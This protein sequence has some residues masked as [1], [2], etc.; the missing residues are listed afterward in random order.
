MTIQNYI[1]LFLS[2]QKLPEKKLLKMFR[3][4][5]PTLNRILAKIICL[6]SKYVAVTLQM[7]I[8]LTL[9]FDSDICN[10]KCNL[11]AKWLFRF[12]KK[13]NYMT[14]Q[15]QVILEDIMQQCCNFVDQVWFTIDA[16]EIRREYIIYMDKTQLPFKI[17]VKQT[18]ACSREDKECKNVLHL[19]LVCEFKW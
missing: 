9:R 1:H 17:E 5:C 4:S 19:L 3:K 8:D 13:N 6:R 7:S 18:I 16:H 15:T 2:G 12:L 14:Y 11:I 10:R